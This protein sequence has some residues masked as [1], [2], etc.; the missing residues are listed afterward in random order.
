MD[1]AFCA[2]MREAKQGLKKRRLVLLQRLE[3][4]IPN[5]F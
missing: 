1:E 5:T 4:K 3:P 2:R